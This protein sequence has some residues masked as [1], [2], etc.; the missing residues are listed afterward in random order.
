MNKKVFLLLFL[1]IGLLVP[2]VAAHKSKGTFDGNTNDGKSPYVSNEGHYGNG[3][4]HGKTNQGYT[5]KGYYSNGDFSMTYRGETYR[6]T[7]GD[8]RISGW[9]HGRTFSGHYRRN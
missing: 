2:T 5:A 9:G 6:G 3:Y 4:A 8:G 1:A 7:Y